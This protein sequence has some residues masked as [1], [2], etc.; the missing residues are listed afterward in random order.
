MKSF[1]ILKSYFFFFLT[2]NK[3]NF[4]VIKENETLDFIG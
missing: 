4:Q 1:E 2:G 3:V